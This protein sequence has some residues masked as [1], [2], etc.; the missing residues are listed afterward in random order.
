MSGDSFVW[1]G[2]W[3]DS[4]GFDGQFFVEGSWSCE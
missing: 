1:R 4:T 2:V 3:G